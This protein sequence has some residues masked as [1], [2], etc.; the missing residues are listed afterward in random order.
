M[1]LIERQNITKAIS[2]FSCRIEVATTS[3]MF[4]QGLARVNV[5]LCDSCA[6]M[7]E[8]KIFRTFLPMHRLPTRMDVDDGVLFKNEN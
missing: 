6:T 5:C 3:C 2:C 4:G 7:P 1:A 8:T